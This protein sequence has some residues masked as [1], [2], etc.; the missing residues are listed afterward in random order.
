[1]ARTTDLFLDSQFE[2][3][4]DGSLFNLELLY[5]PNGTV[6]GNPESLK[7]NLP[8]SHVNGNQDITVL[9]PDQEAYRWNLQLRNNRAQDDFSRIIELAEA[10]DLTGSAL[11][12]A[13]QQVMDVDQWMR[14]YA[15]MT[16]SQG[17]DFYTRVWNHNFRIFQR[18]ADN[19]M[20]AMA[21]DLDG[22]FGMPSNSSLWG[23]TN[24]QKI[25]ELPTNTRLFYGHLLD[26]METTINSTYV[27]TWATHYA[28]LSGSSSQ[29]NSAA[30]NAT[31]RAA[32]VLSQ[33]PAQ[34]PFTITTNA[35]A[36]FSTADSLVTLAGDGWV[37]VREIRLAGN[38]NPL[39]V[40]WT[41]ADSWQVVVPIAPGANLLS[42]EAYNHQGS[43]VGSDSITVTSTATIPLADASNLRITELY[44]NPQAANP[45]PGLGEQA[46]DNDQFEFV[47]LQNI[48]QVDTINLVGAQ[49]SSAVGSASYTFGANTLA[50]GE[51]IILVRDQTAFESRFGTGVNVAGVYAG[52]LQNSGDSITLLA[53]NASVI[54]QFSYDDSGDWPG[55]ADGT[56]SALEIVDAAGDYNDANNWRSSSEFGGSPGFEGA[57][58]VRDVIVN[59]VLSH[60]G[61]AALDLIELYNSSASAVDLDKWY[62]S[63]T[64][65]NLYKFQFADNTTMGAGQYLVL[66]ETQLGFQLDGQ[67][68]ED[69]WLVAADSATGKPIRFAHHVEFEAT[70]TDVSLGR[71]ANGDPGGTLFPMI[72]QTFGSANSGPVLGDVLISE[73]HYHPAPVPPA[74]AGNITQDELEFVELANV[75]GGP[76]DISNWKVDGIHFT[77]PA[78][79]VL[80]ND[81]AIVLVTFDPTLEPAKATAFRNVF[82]IGAGPRL[83]GAASGQLNN[84]GE[85]VELFKPE[86]PVT[87]LTGDVLVDAVR[88]DELAPWPTAAGGG[89]DAL[90]RTA[91]N[92]FGGFAASWQAAPGTPGS[93]NLAI[94]SSGDF[95]G[96]TDVDGADFLA[97]Q[98]GFGITGTAM[99]ADGDANGDNQVDAI[100][101][102]IWQTQFGSSSPLAAVTSIEPISSALLTDESE[103]DVLAA[104][105]ASNALISMAALSVGTKHIA[106]NNAYEITYESFEENDSEE[107]D[108]DFYEIVSQRQLTP[109]DAAIAA[110]Y[111]ASVGNN[112]DSGDSTDDFFS[113]YLGMLSERRYGPDWGWPV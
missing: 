92:A 46:V 14:H 83:F 63:D 94:P 37:D 42:L 24:F 72:T 30:S 112:R 84:A 41:D 75:S 20:V 19:R 82:G 68:D 90:Q 73:V 31:A 107:P 96:D 54:Q 97:W 34:I 100:D 47:E 52:K 69:V 15:L 111:D 65:N 61:G 36:N 6:D 26:L 58:P 13:T 25:I 62:V 28:S 95:D 87:L 3:G 11:D 77:F 51:R 21:W 50:P 109:T 22:L 35:G 49:F 81:E 27:S 78:G 102:G 4:S 17:A 89:G 45:V 53:A 74:E 106:T 67:F 66:N 101:L 104:A 23:G 57:G 113:E 33:I 79:T 85:R 10:F 70:D 80:A 44:Y 32:Y 48:H 110:L 39:E 71:W 76:F 60:S 8:Y 91:A 103:T 93:A 18:P 88:Y 86:D 7:L 1:M 16:L 56:G 38:P 99:P 55:R 40:T 64:N 5:T 9:G 43:L 105:S 2:N 59:E 29:L 12:A 98:R 108:G